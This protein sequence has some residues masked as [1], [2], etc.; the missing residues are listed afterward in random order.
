MLFYFVRKL[1]HL[2][3]MAQLCIVDAMIGTY[4]SYLYENKKKELTK[5]QLFKIFMMSP[6][7]YYIVLLIL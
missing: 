4:I 5:I 3:I 1:L 2:F 6:Y 7:H